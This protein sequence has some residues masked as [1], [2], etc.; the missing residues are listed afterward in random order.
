M[1]P[2]DSSEMPA[3]SVSV[4]VFASPIF[5]LFPAKKTDQ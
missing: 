2:S 3:T 1:S 4:S 5:Y